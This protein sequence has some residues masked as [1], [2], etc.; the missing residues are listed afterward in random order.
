MGQAA[1]AWAAG[2]QMNKSRAAREE[3]DFDSD[4]FDNPVADDAASSPASARGGSSRKLGDADAENPP[5]TFDAENAEDTTL[6]QVIR[7]FRE[8]DADGGGTLDADELVPLMKRLSRP[9]D[10]ASVAQML[11]DMWLAGGQ[12]GAQDECTLEV[13]VEWWHTIGE[14]DQGVLAKS[15]G[16]DAAGV[17]MR[18]AKRTIGAPARKI[19]GLIAEDAPMTK[20]VSPESMF[21]VNKAGTAAARDSSE[22]AERV[23]SMFSREFTHLEDVLRSHEAD[24]TWQEV[25]ETAMREDFDEAALIKQLR[26]NEQCAAASHEGIKEKASLA[27]SNASLHRV[28]LKSNPLLVHARRGKMRE[29][30]PSVSAVLKAAADFVSSGDA[31]PFLDAEVL[32]FEQ[33]RSV[34][35]AALES[36]RQDRLIDVEALQQRGLELGDTPSKIVVKGLRG[37]ASRANGVYFAHGLRA[38]W[39][40]PM[41]VQVPDGQ[42]A[43]SGPVNYLYYDMRHDGSAAEEAK[44]VEGMWILGPS[45]NSERCTA[46]LRERDGDEPTL[47]PTPTETLAETEPS[48]SSNAYHWQVFDVVSHSW[49]AA[50]GMHAPAFEVRVV[51]GDTHT[52]M[53]DYI[54]MRQEHDETMLRQ[55]QIWLADGSSFDEELDITLTGYKGVDGT[56]TRSGFLTWRDTF[57]RDEVRKVQATL[58]KKILQKSWHD[59]LQ[60]SGDPEE[61]KEQVDE[62]INVFVSESIR[63]NKGRRIAKRKFAM[64]MNRPTLSRAFFTW[65]FAVR[66]STEAITSSGM[67]A[68]PV[69]PWNVRHPRSSFSQT[70]EMVQAIVLIYVAFSVIFRVSFNSD[71]VGKT[72][73]FEYAVDIYFSFDVLLNL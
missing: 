65:K 59:M 20:G 63:G 11:R 26:W 44:W 68:E 52:T 34:V 66:Q 3:K 15:S 10:P 33:V 62:V 38:F 24:G 61:A 64:R 16:L 7:L 27:I 47:F 60:L 45:L 41:Y 21:V 37:E 23:R 40:R 55:L 14:Y 31:E 4:V 58:R 43:Q 56:I 12:S 35:R 28:F 1:T 69:L 9:S 73:L 70:W 39:G 8:F 72:A 5:I 53:Q 71:A 46:Y 48:E 30:T 18:R 50:P 54:Q 57:Y 49:I 22:V 2:Q 17:R 19:K 67:F 6:S 51:T 36:E 13:F 29:I 42:L 25:W 32:P